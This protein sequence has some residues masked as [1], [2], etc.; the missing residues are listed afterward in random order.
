MTEKKFKSG[1]VS[2]I[3]RPNVG[4]S[5]LLN[6]MVGEKIAIMSDKP[7]T[8][9]NKVLAILSTEDCQVVFMDTPGIHKPKNK[10]GEYMVRTATDTM[11]E[12][13]VILLVVEADKSVGSG[14]LKII[15]D[16]RNIDTPIILVIN[17][18]DLVKK[19]LVLPL[20]EKYGKLYDFH[21]IIPVSALN[22]DGINIIIED[23]KKIIPQG[24]QYYPEDM[25]TDQ[26]EK[27]IAAEIIREKI[28]QLLQKEVPHGVAVEVVSMKNGGNKNV[29]EVSANIYCEKDSH[30][31]IIIGNKGE[32][33]KKIGS[34][35]RI[36]I[37]NLLS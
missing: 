36:D 2:I 31:G 6:Q 11:N 29:L 15:E 35:A 37:E 21:A 13:D 22:N 32:T 33:L 3:G 17:K 34:L 26:P 30:K 4:K 16:L 20:I 28:L 27:Q 8:T 7:Q 9:R 12:V 18:I 5:T 10:L 25:I 1:F 24:P 14:E 23:I 19:D